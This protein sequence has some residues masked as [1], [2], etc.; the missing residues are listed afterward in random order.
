MEYSSYRYLWPPRPE[1]AVAP[2]SLA[3]FEPMRWWAQAK[4]DGTNCTVYVPPAKGDDAFAMGRAGADNRLVWQPGERWR[5]FESYLPGKG[6]YAFQGE[7]L[8]TRGVGV[9]DTIFLFDLLVDDGEYLIGTT[10]A[11]RY[12]R[13]AT[14]CGNV[15]AEPWVE[16]THMVITPGVWLATNRARAFSEWF[17]AIRNLPGKPPVEGLVF[18][19]P[20][21]KL[22]PCTRAVSN[23]V[24]QRKC[25][26][27]TDHLSF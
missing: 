5:T 14:L 27:P 17:A 2:T 6:W 4:M 23:A 10:Y 7:L 13:L 11:E 26:R 1:E 12:H 24:W 25:R 3:M 20:N 19:N 8:H 16:D 9:R 21:G 15:G 22:A 18:K